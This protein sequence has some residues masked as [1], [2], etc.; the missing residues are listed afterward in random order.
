MGLLN[1]LDAA[2]IVSYLAGITWIGTRFYQKH[3]GMNEYL[4]GS[5]AM[6]WFPVALSIIA[7]DTSAIS[8]LGVPAW[9]FQ[10]DMKLNQNILMFLIAIPLFIWLFLPIYSRGNLYTAYQYLET[11]F[12]LKL[13]LLASLFFLVI[14]GAHVAVIIYAPALMM[15]ELMGVPLKL[16]I[17]V[18]GALTAF[19]TTLGGIKGVIW[20][21]AIQVATVFVGFTAVALSVL[22]HIPGGLS[23]ALS[24]A[25]AEGKFELFDFSLSLEKVDNFWAILIGGTILAVQPL[26]TDQ[27]ILQKFFTTKSA[28]ETSKSLYFYGAVMIPLMTLLS[29]LGVLMYVLYAHQPALR[30]SLKNPDALIPH[31]AAS[32]LPHGLAG[33]VVASIFA[34]SMSTV[35]ASLNSLAT[36]S[37]ID[38]YKRLV[39]SNQSDRHYASASRWATALWGLLAT[40][41]ALYADRLGEL[42]LAFTRIQ[43]LMAG[44]ILGIFLLGVLFKKVGS[45]GAM[46]GVLIGLGAVIYVSVFTTA[47]IFWYGVI[48]TLATVLAG[49]LYSLVF[50]ENVRGEAV[51]VG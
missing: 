29:I 46:A 24:T 13:R 39:K 38:I 36:S 45:R 23:S 30:A 15:S 27:A 43:S 5:K 37:V 21:D 35:S 10:H 9:S 40:V 22:Y 7:A 8:Y 33:L 18:M 49:W 41:G 47:S 34:G 11:R 2:V 16:S 44:T 48:G 19:Y 4:L 17:L 20:T 3:T 28:R 51:A 1:L 6:K 50:P 31:Y 26:C 12:D 42:V 14:R 32:M 25:V